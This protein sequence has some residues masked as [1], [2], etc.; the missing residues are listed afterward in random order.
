MRSWM[1]PFHDRQHTSPHFVVEIALTY[2]T[3][4]LILPQTKRKLL[5]RY[6]DVL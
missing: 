3:V 4:V 5:S 1:H 6:F 2:N